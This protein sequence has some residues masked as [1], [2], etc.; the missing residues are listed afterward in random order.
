MK[1]VVAID[2]LKG[3]LSSMEAG[4]SIKEG[5]LRVCDAEV[6]VKPLADGGEGTVD[7]LLTGIGGK[8]INI[9]VTGPLGQKLPCKYGILEDNRTAVL[10]MAAAAGISLVPKEA[11]NPLNTTTYGVGEMINDAIQ[12]GCRKFIIGIGGSATNDGGIGM[13]QALGYEFVDADHVPVGPAGRELSKIKGIRT[14]GAL[15]ELKECSFQIA[16]DVT[17]PLFGPNGASHVFGPQ[18]GATPEIV[19]ILDSGL[20]SFAEVVKT[21]LGKDTAAVPGTGAAGGLGYAFLTFLNSTLESGISIILKEIKLEDDIR[22]ADFVITG[23]GKL[24]FQTAMGKAPI[25]VA[26]LAK[27]YQKKV[28]A[29]AG[30]TTKDAIRCN[31]EGIDAFFSILSLPMTVEEA[32]ENSTAKSNL[33]STTVQVFRLIKTLQA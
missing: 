12:R 14:D 26:K 4:L 27:K 9:T 16:C 23:E 15:K 22:D 31:D 6:I 1:I 20:Q 17:N 33:I 21:T 7:A 11:L 32:M 10:E 18:K 29:F 25:G 30:G 5:I 3:S 28:I 19:E 2:S 13:L 24:D 8:E